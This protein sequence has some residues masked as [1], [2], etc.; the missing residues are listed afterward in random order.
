[1]TKCQNYQ[2]AKIGGGKRN[3]GILKL[4]IAFLDPLKGMIW[5]GGEEVQ[6]GSAWIYGKENYL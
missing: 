6:M 2:S 5:G 4:K 3:R 1:M